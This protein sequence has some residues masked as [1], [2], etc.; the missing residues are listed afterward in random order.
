MTDAIQN[1]TLV[2]DI[3]DRRYINLTNACTL[4]CSFCPKNQGSMQVHD[5][6][7]DMKKQPKASEV[8]DALGD[9]T[10]ISEVVFCGYGE[11]TLRLGP[12]IEIAAYVKWQGI[13]VR[14]NTDGLA[15]LVHGR[16]VLPEMAK[17]VD[18][19]SISLNAQNETVYN[20]H[21]LPS[22]KGAYQALLEFI[23]AAPL[24]IEK[25]EVSAID[26]LE[27]VDIEACRRIVENAGAQF[28]R[29]VLDEVG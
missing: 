28:K 29:R 24:Y 9:L 4:K 21:C 3:G 18:A 8:I 7:L 27:G 1:T 6:Q 15:N 13:P 19:L 25:V 2:Y 26:G 11:S 5:F 10:D 20:R 14:V 16:N 23:R 17:V 12:L 22:K